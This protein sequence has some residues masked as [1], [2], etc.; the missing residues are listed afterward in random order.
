MTAP[1]ALARFQLTGFAD[2]IDDDP[3]VQLAVLQALG[4]HFIEV[5]SAWGTNVADFSDSQVA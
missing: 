2:E 4:A 3:L 1:A 5:R